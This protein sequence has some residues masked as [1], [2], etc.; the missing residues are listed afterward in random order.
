MRRIF[1]IVAV[2]LLASGCNEPS[3]PD[4]H[5]AQSSRDD[6]FAA[7]DDSAVG[8]MPKE[9]KYAKNRNDA[10]KSS[11]IHAKLVSTSADDGKIYELNIRHE[12]PGV[13][14]GFLIQGGSFFCE[15]VAD[16]SLGVSFDSEPPRLLQCQPRRS[17]HGASAFG[18]DELSLLNRMANAE[19]MTLTLN[20]AAGQTKVTFHP[21]GFTL[22][23]IN[24]PDMSEVI[25]SF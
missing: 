24:P 19:V 18:Y 4:A 25:G 21:K 1:L 20:R 10:T 11:I 17:A 8:N 23:P 16:K 14:E 2:A 12:R 22:S 5:A 7:I 15:G 3:A 13:T 9:W 6:F